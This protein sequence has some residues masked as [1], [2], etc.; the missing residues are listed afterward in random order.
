MN[1]FR[2]IRYTIYILLSIIILGFIILNHNV[3]SGG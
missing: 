2:I 1:D 3:E